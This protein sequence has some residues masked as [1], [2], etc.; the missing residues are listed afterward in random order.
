MIVDFFVEVLW[1]IIFKGFFW[2][3]P[4]GIYCLFDKKWQGR[5]TLNII[6]TILVY[7]VPIVALIS[8]T[9]YLILR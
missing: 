7:V 2:E 4:K 9:V 5:K 3:I 6:L 8:Y 1:E